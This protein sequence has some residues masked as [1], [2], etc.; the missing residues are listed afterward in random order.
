MILV[1]TLKK[2]ILLFNGYDFLI[3]PALKTIL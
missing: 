1:Q 2:A 3:V